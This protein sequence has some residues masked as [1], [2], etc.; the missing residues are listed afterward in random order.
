MKDQI[1]I[2]TG[3]NSGIGKVSARELASKGARV[4][5]VC[6]NKDKGL[7]ALQDIKTESQSDKVE[8]MIADLA[9]QQEIRLLAEKL[10]KKFPKIHILINNAGAVN[11][12]RTETIDKIETT[13]ATNHLGYFLLTMLLLDNL[14]AAP[15]ARIINLASQAQQSGQIYFDD[16]NLK[17]GY[18]SYKSYCQSKLANIMFTYELARR[19]KST[20]V[21]VNCVHPGV[22]RTGFGMNLKGTLKVLLK[23]FSPLM[24]TPEKGAE[25]VVWLASSP[26]VEGI[27]GKYFT[28]KK[29]IKSKPV[30]YDLQA[31]KQLW[32]VSETMTGLG[33]I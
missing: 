14:K 11:G 29:E 28:D 9:S 31:C 13:F 6:R 19:L 27:T 25:T 15:K 33:K 21:T 8:L 20:L 7:A 26:E 10:K 3:A 22:V 12:Q 30:S 18:S 24:R 2:V 4:I 16:L 23:L 1:C 17:N 32:E 5:M